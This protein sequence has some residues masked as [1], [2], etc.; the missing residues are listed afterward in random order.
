MSAEASVAHLLSLADIEIGGPDPWDIQVH[1]PRWFA[2]VL[3][4]GS[5]ALGESYMDGWWDAPRID[6]LITRVHEARL[7]RHIKKSPRVLWSLVQATLI[8]EQT[9]ARAL[10][11]GRQHYDV[12]NDLYRRML[13]RR[14]T[15]SC[16][17]WVDAATLDEAQE[18]KL[19]L[20]CRKLA[21]EPGMRVLDIG[22][23]WGSFARFAAENYGAHVVG[24]TI[25][26]EQARLAR[27]LCAGL[28]VT[29]KLEDYR[30]T[31]GVFDRVV[32]IGM[33]EHVGRK[34]YA[35]FFRNARERL[36]PDGLML[37]HSI[38]T[39]TP[40][41]PDPWARRYIFPNSALPAMGQVVEASQDQFD[42]LDWH[43][44]GP[45]Y[46]PTLLAWHDNVERHWPELE[47]E[48]GPR[49]HRMWTYYLL[50]CAA[51]F[52][53]RTCHVWQIVLAPVGSRPAYR[54]IR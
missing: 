38:G 36:A 48:Y 42:V 52:R 53:A 4:G 32:S 2:R 15:Y 8:N 45:N 22:C 30:A 18:A 16:G 39:N 26:A 3:K 46:D 49:F 43:N 50:S 5:L 31:E 19:D 6:A 44:I 13:D 40:H 25:S 9:P 11:V 24:V 23:G 35:T 7:V 14:M 21:L 28:P 17:Y 47:P 41:T 27:E 33:F 20:I 37:L 1:E 29:I 12:G 51:S 34:N 54:S 10:V